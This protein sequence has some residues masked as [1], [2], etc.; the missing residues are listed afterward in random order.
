MKKYFIQIL[1]GLL[2]A[3]ILPLQ[4]KK[5]DAD[6]AERLAQNYVQSKQK[7]LKKPEVRLKYTATNRH[8]LPLRIQQM[9]VPEVQDTTYFYV[10]NIND[11]SGSGFVIIAGDDAVRPVLGYSTNGNYDENNLPPNFA[12]WMETLQKQIAYAQTQNLPQTD[13]VKQ[14][15]E[16]YMSGNIPITA[17][18]VEPLIKTKWDQ[19]YP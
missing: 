5:V 6:K 2:C 1:C 7:L 4:A 3:A 9:N 8:A 12:W 10:F 11:S 13:A 14:E 19:G 16:A 15:W 18:S 17:S